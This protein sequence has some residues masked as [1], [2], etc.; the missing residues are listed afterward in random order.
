MDERDALK[1]IHELTAAATAGMTSRLEAAVHIK[2]HSWLR[3]PSTTV[4]ESAVASCATLGLEGFELEMQQLLSD[5]NP[6]VR[7]NAVSYF[8]SFA[9]LTPDVVKDLIAT[10]RDP[11]LEVR[12]KAREVV[13]EKVSAS[14]LPESV[15]TH[16]ISPWVERLTLISP[17]HK[18]TAHFSGMP[19][20]EGLPSGGEIKLENWLVRSAG[21]SM[22]WSRDSGKLAYPRFTPDGKQRMHVLD[23]VNERRGFWPQ[24]DNVYQTHAFNAGVLHATGD[25]L[26]ARREHILLLKDVIWA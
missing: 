17:D 9:F 15:V 26:G 7:Y 10:M 4:K 18:Y 2:S 5:H 25:P 6:Q 8:E 14:R 13:A 20:G 22:I 19:I 21:A 1:H 24:L 16:P 23:V 3:H 11:N 12:R